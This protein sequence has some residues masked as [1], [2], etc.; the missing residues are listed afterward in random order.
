MANA[1]LT[2]PSHCS[3]PSP[4]AA[5]KLT[6]CPKSETLDIEVMEDF[7]LPDIASEIGATT[8]IETPERTEI[9]GYGKKR[10]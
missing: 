9:K 10:R 4:D 7:A 2:M 6:F 8:A 5:I 1:W 3:G